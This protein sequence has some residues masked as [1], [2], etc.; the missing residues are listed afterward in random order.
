MTILFSGR[1]QPPGAVTKRKKK[2]GSG[3]KD[4]ADA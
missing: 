3:T 1:I 4:I 2:I